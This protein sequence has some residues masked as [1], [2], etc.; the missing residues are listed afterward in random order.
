MLFNEED[1][2]ILATSTSQ[3]SSPFNGCLFINGN[4]LSNYIINSCALDNVMPITISHVIGLYLTKTFRCCYSMDA[5]K[6]PLIDQVKYFQ[7]ALVS[8]PTKI[9]NL[10]ILV[11]DISASYDML[12]SRSFFK[13]VEGEIKID[14]SYVIIHVGD[15]KIKLDPK[16]KAK[17]IV[18]KSDNP[19]AQ[20]LYQ[21]MEC[22]NYMMFSN[23]STLKEESKSPSD[24]EI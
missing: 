19:K 2:S 24:Q 13:Y 3:N 14:W 22:W 6:V 8:H 12:L 7:V 15:K 20:I 9:F 1:S 4:K 17:F 11:A 5:K 10:V 16:E 23:F 21:E 18:T